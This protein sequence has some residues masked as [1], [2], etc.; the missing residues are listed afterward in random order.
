ME[1]ELLGDLGIPGSEES[2]RVIREEV[3]LVDK[4]GD[5][6]LKVLTR[7]REGREDNREYRWGELQN[8][9]KNGLILDH[10]GANDLSLRRP[11]HNIR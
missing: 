4:V 7:V 11:C 8:L 9:V 2:R 5:T 6:G 10:S 3:V 1:R